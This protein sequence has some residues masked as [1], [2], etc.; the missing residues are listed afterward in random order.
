M[1]CLS[2]RKPVTLNRWIGVVLPN[3]PELYACAEEPHRKEYELAKD[4]VTLLFCV[5]KTGAH[6]MKPLFTSKYAS[7]WCFSHENMNTLSLVYANSGNAWM[8]A[9]IFQKWFNSTFVPVVRRHLQ[10]L[11]P[12]W[13]Q[14]NEK[15]VPLLLNIR[16]IPLIGIL[17]PLMTV[18]KIKTEKS[19]SLKAQSQG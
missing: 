3:V 4:R 16:K 17:W 10:Q 11:R 2:W 14:L 7:P 12:D 6:K 15:T 19:T 9:K 1:T 13:P 5:N 8:T 18:Q